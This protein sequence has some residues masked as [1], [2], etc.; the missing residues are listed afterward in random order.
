MS[1]ILVEQYIVS[2]SIHI[3]I[4]ARNKSNLVDV[5]YGSG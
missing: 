4:F 1:T 5:I 3:Y 2:Y